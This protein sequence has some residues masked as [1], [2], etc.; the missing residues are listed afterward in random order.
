MSDKVR[1]VLEKIV[2]AGIG[3]VAITAEKAKEIVNEMIAKGELSVEQGKA[4]N[5]ELKYAFKKGGTGSAFMDNL[6]SLDQL[7]DDQ[8]EALK[9]R[10]LDIENRRTSASASEQPQDAREDAP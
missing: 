6:D 9:A 5:E 4:I 10:L 8:L 3:A 7:D 1:G 2:L